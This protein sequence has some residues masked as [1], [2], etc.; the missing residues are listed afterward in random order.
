MSLGLFAYTLAGLFVGTSIGLTGI[1]GGSMMAPLLIL[2]FHIPA[3]QAVQL[4]FL[5]L[6]PTKLAGAWQHLRHKSVDPTL[7]LFLALGALPGTALGSLY[8]SRAVAANPAM[9]LTLRHMIGVLILMSAVLIV[10][11]L[12]RMWRMNR[13][14][15]ALV[16]VKLETHHR[17]LMVVVG[18]AVGLFVGATSIGAGSILLPLLVLILRVRMREL[19]S[20]DVVL[21]AG[22]AVVGASIH[23]LGQT[24]PW[25]LVAALLL[26]SVPGALLGGKLIGIISTRL[27][28][29]FVAGALFIA[30]LV[31]TG[32]L[33]SS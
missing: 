10:I 28:R 27:V 15:H 3:A 25:S 2:V 16:R 8:V 6:T 31:L 26:G 11:Q 4:D 23:S 17:I 18:L 30:G 29:G 14:D 12:V 32:I 33:Q 7:T 21:G 1:G 19:V 9:N 20:T 24:I 22:M 5:Y 13:G